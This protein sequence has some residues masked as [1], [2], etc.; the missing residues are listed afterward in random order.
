MS[1]RERRLAR[2]GL[3]LALVA[4]APDADRDPAV[5]RSYRVPYRTTDTNHAVV[6]VRVNGVGPFNFLVDTGAP[7]LY[8]GTEAAKQIGLEASKDDYWT[9][10]DRLDFEGGP[11]LSKVQGPRRGPLPARRDE[12]P[13]PAG[14]SRST[15]SSATRPWPASASRSTPP[16]TG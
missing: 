2:L 4:L 9:V 8:V 14:A 5:G 13:G 10:V 1:R 16:T 12:R 6:R 15:A 3:L 11:T 7:A